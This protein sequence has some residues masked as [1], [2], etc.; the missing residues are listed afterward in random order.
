MLALSFCLLLIAGAF[1]GVLAARHLRTERPPPAWPLGVVHGLI[2]IGGLLALLLALRGPSRGEA[3]GVVAFG[4]V[5][6]W[7]LA[8]ALLAGLAVLVARQRWRLLIGVHAT[9][10]ISGIVILAAYVLAG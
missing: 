7:L 2:G 9:A 5:A 10:A 1:G 6:A 8:F 3:M 4:G